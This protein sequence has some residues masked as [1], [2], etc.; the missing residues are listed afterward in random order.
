[1][2]NL[3][4]AGLDTSNYT[5]SL[6]VV[7]EQGSRIVDRRIP[8]QVE[9]GERG[10]RQQ[11]AVFQHIRNLSALVEDI[12]DLHGEI[13]TVTSSTKPRMETTSY[14]PVFEVSKNVGIFLSG[15]TDA[16]WL[17]TSHQRG[18]L[19]V[20]L[21]GVDEDPVSFIGLHISGGTTEVLTGNYARGILEEMI[22]GGTSD[23]S[24]GQLIDRIGVK[25]GFAFPAGKQM[26]QLME[27][28]KLEE[29]KKSYR[30]KGFF[31]DGIMNLSGLENHLTQRLEHG[32]PLDHIAYGTFRNVA[33][34]LERAILHYAGSEKKKTVLLT[35][36]VAANT[37]IREYLMEHL[38]QKDIKPIFCS[39]KDCTDNAVGA[40]LIGLDAYKRSNR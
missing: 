7:D 11:E 3:L 27:A 9:L 39:K 22:L 40:A 38:S 26:D 5:T 25:M 28:S 29:Y 8:L 17:E 2:N 15:M 19:R 36:G 6:A 32:D 18:H 30:Y 33:E 14:M 31:K 1:M 34:V 23:I 20:A 10:L 37:L 4:F 13:Q 21:E 16:S 24:A 12:H 35:G